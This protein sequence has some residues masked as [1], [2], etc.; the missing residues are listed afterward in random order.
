LYELLAHVGAWWEEAEGII[1][2]A[3]EKRERP[4]ANTTSTS[5]TPPRWRASRTPPGTISSPG[6]SRSGR[7]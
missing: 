1:R 4:R 5:L 3:L 2:D 6:M 7:R